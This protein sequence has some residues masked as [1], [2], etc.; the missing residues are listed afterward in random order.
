MCDYST[1]L[2]FEEAGTFW[3]SLS[4]RLEW[5][6]MSHNIWVKIT[7]RFHPSAIANA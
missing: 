7:N 2:G 6:W 3:G 1:E 5:D 4:F